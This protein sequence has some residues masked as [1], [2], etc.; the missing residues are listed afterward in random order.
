MAVL[1]LLEHLGIREARIRCRIQSM[2]PEKR[3]WGPSAAVGY[4]AISCSLTI[5]KRELD[6]EDPRK[7]WSIEQKPLP[8]RIQA[9][10][11]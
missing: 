2:V 1:R 3:G 6:D 8:H 9:V 4:R 10:G 5:I 7:S 11:C